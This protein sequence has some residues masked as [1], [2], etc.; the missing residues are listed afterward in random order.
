MKTWAENLQRVS[1]PFSEMGNMHII[2]SCLEA[3]PLPLQSKHE[4]ILNIAQ[5]Q[6][7][8]KKKFAETA[9]TWLS[10]GL[11]MIDKA[12]VMSAVGIWPGITSFLLSNYSEG[13][14]ML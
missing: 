6:W 13:D 2:G 3:T 1:L 10:L 8:K 14:L 4:T 9:D 7:K 11:R 5:T 12:N